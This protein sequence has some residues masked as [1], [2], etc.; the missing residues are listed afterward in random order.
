MSNTDRDQDWSPSGRPQSYVPS[1][2]HLPP[3]P[4]TR[5]RTIAQSFSAQLDDIFD[6]SSNLD[7]LSEN[8]EQKKR[9]V[10]THTQ[11]L[12]A[13]EARLRETEERLKV[14]SNSQ[15]GSRSPSQRRETERSLQKTPLVA[16]AASKASD[17]NRNHTG[18]GEQGAVSGV[19]QGP[20]PGSGYGKRPPAPSKGNSYNVPPMPGGM[21]D[22]PTS[23][24]SA[25]D[26]VM[27]NPSRGS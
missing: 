12:E 10:D 6:M 20:R 8:V 14:V 15:P 23:R 19:N 26:Y 17:Y 27:V 4:L 11:E 25:K 5:A 3:L 7:S 22:T 24:S 2:Y 21:P 9:T 13:L 16:D 18:Y 1:V